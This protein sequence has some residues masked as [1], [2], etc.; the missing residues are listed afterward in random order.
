MKKGL[1]ALLTSIS[2]L[3]GCSNTPVEKEPFIFEGKITCV[4]DSLTA[5]HNWPNESYPNYIKDYLPEGSNASVL[6]CGINGASFKT[7]GQYNP[8]YNT[9]Q[10]YRDS[11]KEE[12]APDVIT[13]LLG[14]NDATN[15]ANE[16]DLYVDDYTDLVNLYYD[17]FGDDIT[18]IMLTSPRCNN[19]TFGIPGDVIVNNVNPL[20]EAIADDLDLP[21]IDTNELF[22]D[23]S[24]AELFRD[25][26]HLTIAAAKLVAEAIADKIVE[27]LE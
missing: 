19:N 23:Y 1:L 10:Q 22:A 17:T 4:G 11:L 24:D 9:T 2:F 20:Q 21:I 26:V 8:A 6:N 15:W 16:K 13:I 7:F 3:A 18:I 12:N 27:V 5:G 14:T 25:G